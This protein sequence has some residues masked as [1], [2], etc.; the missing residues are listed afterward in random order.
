M[1]SRGYL[2]PS[3]DNYL[4]SRSDSRHNPLP[5]PSVLSRLRLGAARAGVTKMTGTE[6]STFERPLDEPLLDD[7][8]EQE[9]EAV[10]GAR[11]RKQRLARRTFRWG[12]TIIAVS[13]VA[14]GLPVAI[15]FLTA[16]GA[17]P[18]GYAVVIASIFVVLATPI[19][20]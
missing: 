14:V 2:A 4:E 7:A 18:S 10:L 5:A 16:R 17:R 3:G 19:S 20:L 12:W 15:V 9:R 13:S 6:G 8:S 1:L 11:A